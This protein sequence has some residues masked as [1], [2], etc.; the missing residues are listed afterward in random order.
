MN[1]LGK[2]ELLDEIGRG[3]ITAVYRARH[4]DTHQTVLLKPLPERISK[5]ASVV[6]KL[7]AWAIQMKIPPH[8]GVVPL[9]ALEEENGRYFTTYPEISGGT[10]RE[11]I[12][13]LP[14]EEVNHILLR[15]TDILKT[16][17]QFEVLHLN[18]KP[19]NVL[20]D[21]QGKIYVTDVGLAAII[22]PLIDEYSGTPGYMSPEQIEGR[23]VNG[24]CDFY[25]LGLLLIEMLTGNPTYQ[26]DTSA[27]L[28][29]NQ[30]TQPLPNL[31]AQNSEISPL[32]D[33][34]IERLSGHERNMRPESSTEAG[35]MI[36]SVVAQVEEWPDTA[37]SDYAVDLPIFE[38]LSL[39]NRR[40]LSREDHEK[41]TAAIQQIKHE[42]ELASQKRMENFIAIEEERQ[43]RVREQLAQQ[44]AQER[45][46]FIILGSVILIGLLG[47]IGYYLTSLGG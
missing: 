40:E 34:L 11:K 45:T 10:L 22:R 20:F 39:Y 31:H 2:Y 37:D 16:L 43:A 17:H 5:H 33:A 18:L 7:Q 29:V 28:V 32:Y 8:P 36:L 15:L 6:K 1:K 21:E 42:E 44:K 47:L 46:V 41:R 14:L 19:E 26:A 24:R 38:Y 35:D 9:L 3:P 4:V 23:D 27:R 12:G 13:T 30:M 25:S